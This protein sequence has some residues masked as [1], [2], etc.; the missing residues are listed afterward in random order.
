MH[1]FNESAPLANIF[2]CMKGHNRKLN[3]LRKESECHGGGAVKMQDRVLFF[4]APPSSCYHIGAMVVGGAHRGLVVNPARQPPLHRHR[5]PSPFFSLFL[6]F[7][8]QHSSVHNRPWEV[9]G[10]CSL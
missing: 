8:T 3:R 5:S 2:D 7:F 10:Y 1:C 9:M 4:S 6:F